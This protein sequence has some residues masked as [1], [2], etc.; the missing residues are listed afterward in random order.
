MGSRESGPSLVCAELSGPSELAS[1]CVCVCICRSACAV[2][3]LFLLLLLLHC[4][5]ESGHTISSRQVFWGWAPSWR[6]WGSWRACC[7]GGGAC[8]RCRSRPSASQGAPRRPRRRCPSGC[9]H[10]SLPGSP[11]GWLLHWL[12]WGCAWSLDKK[13]EDEVR[14]Q[15]VA[16]SKHCQC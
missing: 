2:A 5:V 6:W 12:R 13:R 16:K 4:R 3:L 1:L 11:P 14:Q 8:P 10:D 15:T 7:R 9:W